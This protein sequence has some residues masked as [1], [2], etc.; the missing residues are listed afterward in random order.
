MAALPPRFWLLVLCCAG[1][2]AL[3]WWWTLGRPRARRRQ[4]LLRRIAEFDAGA[5][6]PARA[7]LPAAL[8]AAPASDALHPWM[9]FVGNATADPL[10]LLALEDR[11]ELFWQARQAAQ[12]A[13]I[14]LG[15]EAVCDAADPRARSLW[16]RA[17]LAL[18]EQRPALP[19]NGIVLCIDALGLL[20]APSLPSELLAQRLRGMLDETTQL[21]RLQLPVYVLV[22]GLEKLRG[23]AEVARALPPAVRAQ[24]V[25]H[26]L[27][28]SDGAGRS[29]VDRFEALFAPM[30][31]RL[32]AL[33]A[34]LL[35]E[36]PDPAVRLAMQQWSEQV[37]ALQPGLRRLVGQL[38][39]PAGAARWRGVYLAAA[40]A[41]G[42]DG[43]FTVDLLE[44]L[45]PADQ[46]L[47]R[48]L[49]AR[50]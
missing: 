1:A 37:A 41:A 6:D 27:P 48:P 49:A 47:A 45:L 40:A 9:L 19:L 17:L 34:A 7:A 33:A 39:E 20:E 8:I 10:R 2:F 11:P 26:R 4:G 16:F 50:P 3:L 32:F 15:P 25:G 13:A 43:L 23:H 46:P 24:A 36:E 21:L 31:D 30:R 28:E 38:F 14:A 5:A 42:R 29:A 22:T 12:M 18:S 35:R 44:R